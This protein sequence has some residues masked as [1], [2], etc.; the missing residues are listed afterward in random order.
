MR[1]SSI[2]ASLGFWFES[3]GTSGVSP[4]SSSGIGLLGVERAAPG[5]AVDDKQERVELLEAPHLRGRAGG[6]LIA[7]RP[8]V[9]ACNEG[10]R[11][12]EVGGVAGSEVVA[13][14]DRDTRG[15]GHDVFGDL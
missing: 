3:I 15:N 8:D 12:G 5:A 11:R 13:V 2:F 1:S 14:D 4:V 9:D 10:E 7:A 6:P